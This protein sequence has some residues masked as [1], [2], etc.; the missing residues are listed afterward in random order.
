[1][2]QSLNFHLRLYDHA[3]KQARQLS[4]NLGFLN[5]DFRTNIRLFLI[6]SATKKLQQIK[7]LLASF[8]H[9]FDFTSKT[10]M[11]LRQFGNAVSSIFKSDGSKQWFE[12]IHGYFKKAGKWAL[13][14]GD[15]LV[16]A[17]SI[18]GAAITAA[19][20]AASLIL[21]KQLVKINSEMEQFEVSLRTTLG[22]LTAAKKEMAGIVEFA[23]E[24]PYEIKNIT[25]AVVKLRSYA[26]DADKWLEPLGN[27]ASA[28]GRDITDAVEMAADTVMGM[29]RRAL[30]YG[31]RFEKE[32]FKKG[33]KYAGMT[34]ADA[35]MGELEKRF[36]G[37]M[38]LQAKTV[39]GIWSNVKDA[40]YIQFQEATKPFYGIIKQQLQK[41]YDTLGSAEGQKKVRQVIDVMI[42]MLQK[43]LEAGKKAYAFIQTTLLPIAQTTGKAM[44]ETF[45]AVSDM[46]TP[47]L[48]ALKPLVIALVS[49][50]TLVSKLVTSSKLAL[51]IFVAFSAAIK[52]MNLLGLSVKKV[53]AGMVA[54]GK[55]ASMLSASMKTL[56]GGIIAAGTSFAAMWAIGNYLEI[57]NNL[58]EIGNEI[59]NM[60]S[61][62]DQVKKK[63]KEIGEEAGHTLKEMTKVA[64]AAKQFGYNMA[65]VI[66]IA[67]KATS[68][69][70]EGFGKNL[71]TDAERAAE[72]IG[73]LAEAFI[74][75]NDS[76][77]VM[78]SKTKAA[79]DMLVNL[80][81]VADITGI[82]FDDMAIA[83][84]GNR[85]V[86]G[87]YADN[88]T[89][90]TFLI[91]E[92]GKAA[93]EAGINVNVGQFLDAL[94]SLLH[95][96]K[97]M[98][99]SLPSSTWIAKPLKDM[100]ID[101]IAKSLSDSLDATDI[102]EALIRAE[103]ASVKLID[104]SEE[105]RNNI[106]SGFDYAYEK[107]KDT[108]AI[109]SAIGGGGGTAPGKEIGVGGKAANFFGT[110]AGTAV[111]TLLTFIVGVFTASMAKKL[112][113]KFNT[114]IEA[115][116]F[117]LGSLSTRMSEKQLAKTLG[118]DFLPKLEK[119]QAVQINNQEKLYKTVFKE[120]EKELSK[121]QKALDKL[122]LGLLKNPAL[123]KAVP[124]G[125]PVSEYINDMMANAPEEFKKLSA[126]QVDA[127]KSGQ[128]ALNNKL[129]DIEK[130]LAAARTQASE[131]M[132][133]L[134]KSFDDLG[135][136]FK[137]GRIPESLKELAA[138][139][140]NV[141]QAAKKATKNAGL[142][143]PFHKKILPG[144]LLQALDYKRS[145]GIMGAP[146]KKGV[147]LNTTGQF[148]YGG[149]RTVNNLKAAANPQ[150]A[151]A[152]TFT[153]TLGRLWMRTFGKVKG[154]LTGGG[155][156]GL[157]E[158][159][160]IS[161]FTK[162]LENLSDDFGLARYYQAYDSKD[163]SEV[164][165]TYL[166]KQQAIL[167][168]AYNP[169]GPLA[170]YG[171]F[172]PTEIQAQLQ[173]Y[174]FTLTKDLETLF[175]ALK[176]EGVTYIKSNAWEYTPSPKQIG[177]PHTKMRGLGSI[178]GLAAY[179]H[180]LGH[181][182]DGLTYKFKALSKT[183]SFERL[184]EEKVA[185][186]YSIKML[187]EGNIFEKIRE[188]VIK[189]VRLSTE[190]YVT[191]RLASF[192]DSFK[193]LLYKTLP[194]EARGRFAPGNKYAWTTETAPRF[195]TEKKVIDATGKLDKSFVRL[196][197]SIDNL[198]KPLTKVV[199][200]ILGKAFN[201]AVVA[202]LPDLIDELIKATT[203][204]SIEQVPGIGTYLKDF[205]KTP[206]MFLDPIFAPIESYIE[207]AIS[208]TP[209]TVTY[210][211]IELPDDSL[212][213]IFKDIPKD[214]AASW[215]KA[216]DALRDSLF[217]L[218]EF[219][220]GGTTIQEYY[221]QSAQH[222]GTED[223][224][225][226][227]FAAE[228]NFEK[229]KDIVAREEEYR[230]LMDER[231]LDNTEML[232]K[233]RAAV[234]GVI[235]E[236]IM[237][238]YKVIKDTGSSYA[239][240]IG[241]EFA[242]AS[243]F[244]EDNIGF[245]DISKQQ[246]S[247]LVT[248]F[249]ETGTLFGTALAVSIDEAL[250]NYDFNSPEGFKKFL[251]DMEL[252]NIPQAFK[253]FFVGMDG[254]QMVLTLT[255]E[256]LRKMED[257]SQA[258]T[259][260]IQNL[261][262]EIETITDTID[263]LEGKINKLNLAMGGI[264]AAFDL[265]IAQNEL[266]LTSK[267]VW[268]LEDSISA[269]GK[270]LARAESELLPLEKALQGLQDEFQAIQDEITKTEE[271]IDRLMNNPIEGQQ[272]YD[273]Q[274]FDIDEQI[275][276]QEYAIE[277]AQR[278]LR[279][280]EG[281][282]GSDLYKMASVD[283]EAMENALDILKDSRADM[284]KVRKDF[285][286][287]MERDRTAKAIVDEIT[288]AEFAKLGIYQAQY[289]LLQKQ[290]EEKQ[291]EVTAATAIRD[292]K[293]EEIEAIKE[294][295]ALKETELANLKEQVEERNKLLQRTKDTMNAEKNIADLKSKMFDV[296]N[297]I[298]KNQLLQLATSGSVSQ[299]QLDNLTLMYSAMAAESSTLTGKKAA[300]ELKLPSLQEEV[301]E[302][303]K[304]QT[305]LIEKMEALV[306][307]IDEK[308]IQGVN[309]AALSKTDLESVFGANIGKVI[310]SMAQNLSV[311]ASGKKGAV[312][313]PQN[314]I[315]SIVPD[316]LPDLLNMA[317]KADKK[318]KGGIAWQK[319]LT[320]VAEE[321]PE[322]IIPLQNGSVPVKLYGNTA[323]NSQQSIVVT[324]VTIGDITI[325]VRNDKDLEEIKE[326]IIELKTGDCT[327]FSS[328][329]HYLDR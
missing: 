177:V 208:N 98:L 180:E 256:Q 81:R 293:L 104:A 77:E 260:E 281:F 136:G 305:A 33:G 73:R 76:F 110:G 172:M 44:L 145:V 139:I 146:F 3:T 276:K 257:E 121:T 137:K 109:Y 163:I 156:R 95:P 188:Q 242:R 143:W 26:M 225:S 162:S 78:A 111:A 254:G 279:K 239:V 319:Q 277:Q 22:S 285:T 80:N 268:D 127:F 181:A 219:I 115:N 56:G 296:E 21:T 204:K 141:G 63:L 217:S 94:G 71:E 213:D 142:T 91:A 54:S 243:K 43:I 2:D 84:E 116:K 102:K 323:Q 13:G 105:I 321:V 93:K 74:Q 122:Q 272:E 206:G 222:W 96:T 248:N 70:R 99:L 176:K 311:L 275:R 171:S 97:E 90:L 173:K 201:V 12:K 306:K 269:L 218:Y 50:L 267:T 252:G 274:M 79:G 244:V 15:A 6:D 299:E 327:F 290:A 48:T 246:L 60:A 89:E 5:R 123:R 55:S 198:E 182:V 169:K 259:I 40:L 36:K 53:A 82:T 192:S 264:E 214:F 153:L 151:Y 301:A 108:A 24:T 329:H 231:I 126:T 4:R 310:N 247:E 131:S 14:F 203:G 228:E 88:I 92:F 130:R 167:N 317:G 230:K 215:N 86:L 144:A 150:Q 304:Q 320:W 120:L 205:I 68:E 85:E 52:I 128:E 118:K 283:V 58:K 179:F 294:S 11:S 32:D 186:E 87:E 328:P 187:K 101:A 302:R 193:E 129:I 158:P 236:R 29:P 138:E 266:I 35:L 157:F 207:G 297:L 241:N 250:A 51:Q 1:M 245:G 117:G 175:D 178:E 273:L 265:A 28:F 147:N 262:T 165:K 300:E 154:T 72:A 112:M 200:G 233:K 326:A 83:I 160:A 280:W 229:T 65:N 235:Q 125:I 38:E 314:R 174:G 292:A 159:E 221:N 287:P 318:A 303:Q 170:K 30:S 7:R 237:Q 34:Y 234:L 8:P 119:L 140:D 251:E 106:E 226:R 270:K 59:R 45:S 315:I 67:A 291:T 113:K 253:D 17:F 313:A 69:A 37:G 309:I 103:S 211:N 41:F 202:E 135:E 209:I 62:A 185:N 289:D 134:A 316:Y 240:A 148:M 223:R 64:L 282:E 322:A 133:K 210:G 107:S 183:S 18:G 27:A 161:R 278:E 39:K 232:S 152:R 286:A 224:A 61:G 324:H 155:S 100:D 308:L 325:P 195:Y 46:V 57:R 49:V 190:S 312:S 227:A 220:G 284:E 189:S 9:L 197:K 19:A 66:E 114:A 249:E 216:S 75:E 184:L 132:E 194:N 16:G 199:G 47:L 298:S 42:T 164:W 31:M 25:E 168:D 255:I 166:K 149:Q 258:L 23:K 238:Q 271:A 124:L 295:L 10:K 20:G 212:G 263:D 196:A 288:Y 191:G 307:F 261:N